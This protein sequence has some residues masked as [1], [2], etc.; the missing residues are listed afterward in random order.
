M[1]FWS[2][3]RLPKT[4]GSP[5]ERL[6]IGLVGLGW[7]SMFSRMFLMGLKVC[8]DMAEEETFHCLVGFFILS[9]VIELICLVGT[10]VEIGTVEKGKK[11]F[12]ERDDTWWLLLAVQVLA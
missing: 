11:L 6:I 8:L 10:C 1:I 2:G 4:V 7:R 9:G 5:M 3:L 12:F